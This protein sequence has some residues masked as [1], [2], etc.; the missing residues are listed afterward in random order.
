[1]TSRDV[2]HS[3]YVPAFRLKQDVL[4]GRYVS[5]WF[6]ATETGT[7][8]IFCAEYCGVAHSRMRGD[9]VVLPQ[10]DYDKWLHD[11]GRDASGSSPL[12]SLG[13]TVAEKRACLACHTLNGQ[14]HIGPTFAR[15]F[16]SK[17]KL[18]DGRTVLV[19]EAYLT[20]SMMEPQAD[21]VAGYTTLMPTYAGVLNATETAALV[22]LIRSL[23]DASVPAGV[24]LPKVQ[25]AP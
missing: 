3:F 21:I 16:G 19:D 18:S 17:V 25:E 10:D 8:P 5:L 2:I 11:R 14:P 22:E 23:R 12:V 6:E 13:A 7:F 1:M 20:R 9:V 4:P 24:K 15:L